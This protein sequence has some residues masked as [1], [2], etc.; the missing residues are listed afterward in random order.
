[1]RL[2]VLELLSNHPPPSKHQRT[3]NRKSDDMSSNITECNPN[4]YTRAEG[5][6]ML[7]APNE[8]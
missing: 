7:Q 5:Q 8:M 2:A 6:S 4:T 1:M 3:E